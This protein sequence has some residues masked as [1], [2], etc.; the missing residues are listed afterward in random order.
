MLRIYDQVENREDL[1]YILRKIIIAVGKN[2]PE[3]QGISPRIT[4]FSLPI[5]GK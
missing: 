2:P 5:V 3:I 1:R 4:G